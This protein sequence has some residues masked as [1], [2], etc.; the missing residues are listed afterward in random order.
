[1]CKESV[2]GIW[3]LINALELEGWKGP[4]ECSL[5]EGWR[6]GSHPRVE[7]VTEL[8]SGLLAALA[9]KPIH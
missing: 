4:W 5:V 1:M 7:P 3:D 8:H 9:A 6:L 2:P